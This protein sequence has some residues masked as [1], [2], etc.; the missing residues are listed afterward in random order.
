MATGFLMLSVTFPESLRSIS[1]MLGTELVSNFVMAS[2]ILFLFLQL[3]EANTEIVKNSRTVRNLVCSTTAKSLYRSS[4]ACRNKG[5]IIL[6]CF[7]EEENLPS[8]IE[9][10]KK[11]GERLNLDYC[12]INDGST[13]NS[14]LCKRPMIAIYQI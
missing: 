14:E 9:D 1:D 11:E 2:L 5:L 3:L 13:D 10:I 12:F 4:E 7:N 8:I 6:P